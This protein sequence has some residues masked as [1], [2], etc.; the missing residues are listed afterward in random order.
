MQSGHWHAPPAGG[1]VRAASG[2]S[3]RVPGA[4]P[5]LD[6]RSVLPGS[7]DMMRDRVPRSGVAAAHSLEA[8]PAGQQLAQLRPAVQLPQAAAPGPA[9]DH[10]GELVHDP[11]QDRDQ[12]VP[13]QAGG[14]QPD[15]AGDVETDPARGDHTAAADVGR[16]DPADREP[17]PQCTSGIAYDATTM[18][19]SSATLTTCSSARSLM[20]S[21]EGCLLTRRYPAP[22]SAYGVRGGSLTGSER[23]SATV[24]DVG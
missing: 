21:T 22:A 15:P 16:G 2:G 17:V 8:G 19:G 24:P 12:L 3:P 10:R 23:C 11:A 6:A 5:Y 14:Q 13:A 9:R 7:G 4:Q 18:P 1:D 20:I